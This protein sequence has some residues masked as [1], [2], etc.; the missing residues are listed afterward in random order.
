MR[1]FE[2][3]YL[4]ICD[5]VIKDENGKISVIGIYNV[6]LA[7]QFPVFHPKFVLV[8]NIKILDKNIKDAMLNVELVNSEGNRVGFEIPAV[9]LT[10]IN[11]NPYGEVNDH[12]IIYEIGNIKFDQPGRYAFRVKLESEEIGEAEFFVSKAQE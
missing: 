10:S 4:V 9:K 5:S 11:N 3:N 1:K 6:V 8:G 7:K 12:N 2:K